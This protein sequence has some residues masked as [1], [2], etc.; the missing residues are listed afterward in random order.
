MHLFVEH[1][2]VIDCAYLC[3]QRGLVGESWITDIA[4]IGALDE[5]S[6]VM[7]FALAKKTIK[8]AIDDW[9]DHALLVPTASP[10]LT[11]NKGDAPHDLKIDD[12]G[13]HTRTLT[14]TFGTHSL[15]H[16]SPTQ[17]LCLIDTPRIT[18]DAVKTYLET[19]LM[20]VLP[21]SVERVEVTLR[22]E[23]TD[24]PYYHY[25]HGLKK[26]DGNCQRIAHGHR[27]RIRISSNSAHNETLTAAWATRLNYAYIGTRE[28]IIASDATHTT[29]AYLAPQG[30]YELRYPT[31]LCHLID[32]DSTVECIAAHIATECKKEFP[33]ATHTVRAYEGVMKGA[34]ASA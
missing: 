15:A 30:A 18:A 24:A 34:V 25:V 17:A 3:E 12:H 26:H 27:S 21:A 29:F 1:L 23:S 19:R 4:L 2:T 16:S 5:N 11:L 8:H 7:D 33:N 32:T 13:A 28:D 14:F 31:A 9:V 20:D 10:H 6:M 22:T